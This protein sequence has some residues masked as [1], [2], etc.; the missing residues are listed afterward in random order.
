MA[1]ATVETTV[2]SGE[3]CFAATE[4]CLEGFVQVEQLL[5]LAM[6]QDGML[7][8]D[9]IAHV[10]VIIII[11]QAGITAKTNRTKERLSFVALR[12]SNLLFTAPTSSNVYF[13]VLRYDTAHSADGVIL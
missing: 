6:G 5:A 11:K 1:V 8:D 7:F 3:N 12:M 9:A 10:G 2:K 4:V 13:P